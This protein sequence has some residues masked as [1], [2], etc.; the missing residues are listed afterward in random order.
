M[1]CS[2]LC[3]NIEVHNKYLSI[4]LNI[5]VRLCTVDLFKSKE[6]IQTLLYEKSCQKKS[7]FKLQE[8]E[9]EF[10][11]FTFMIFIIYFS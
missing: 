8:L 2:F 1:Y 9:I 4:Y 3:R 10:H 6:G 7:H 5:N 11:N